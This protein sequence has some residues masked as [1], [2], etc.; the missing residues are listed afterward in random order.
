MAI[1]KKSQMGFLSRVLCA[2]STIVFLLAILM[3]GAG[4]VLCIEP[5]GRVALERD[6]RSSH[7]SEC[8][9]KSAGN[10]DGSLEIDAAACGCVDT[11]VTDSENLVRYQAD[12]L[13]AYLPVFIWELV[14]VV[15]FSRT[16]MPM[17]AVV[18]PSRV[19]PGDALSFLATIVLLI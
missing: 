19:S 12:H 14:A 15:D 11:P 8:P 2:S 1:D 17:P 10:A 3:S 16:S 18:P 7:C 13:L 9:G 4:F 5:D 6:H